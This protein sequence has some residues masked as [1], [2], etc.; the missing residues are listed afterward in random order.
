GTDTFAFSTAPGAG[1]ADQ[2]TDFVSATDKLSFDNAVFNALGAAGNFASGDPRFASGADLTSGQDASDRLIYDTS[3]GQ[4]FYDADGRGAGASQLVATLQGAPALAA[5]DIVVTGQSGSTIQG[6]EGNDTLIG[7]AGND[8]IDGRGGN[9]LI[10]GLDGADSLIGGAGNDTLDGGAGTDTMDGGLGEDTYIVNK[11]DA[12]VL[13][14]AAG[15]GKLII[16]D[17]RPG[18]GLPD[19]LENLTYRGAGSSFT[20]DGLRGNAADNVIRNET[21]SAL[22]EMN[23][24]SGNDT[25]IGSDH[26]DFFDVSAGNDVV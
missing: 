25:L 17:H 12:D 14:D 13:N 7:T 15:T 10:S 24:G 26:R 11:Q 22:L 23:G 2:V 18:A 20:D 3:T 6:T 8:T 16:N 1:N 21:D 19:G 5:T 4:L 9:D